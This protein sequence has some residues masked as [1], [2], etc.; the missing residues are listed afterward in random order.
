MEDKHKARLHSWTTWSDPKRRSQRI[1]SRADRTQAVELPTQQFSANACKVSPCITKPPNDD[2]PYSV[3]GMQTLIRTLSQKPLE[4][5]YL[6]WRARI[7]SALTLPEQRNAE[8]RSRH[9]IFCLGHVLST[10]KRSAPFAKPRE[11][12][13]RRQAPSSG[14]TPSRRGRPPT[15]LW[16]P[17]LTTES[18]PKWQ[19]STQGK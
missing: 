13:T 19:W 3:L 15:G 17:N 12:T 2:N 9:V 14:H 4:K 10:P 11:L 7:T 6:Y 1:L 16:K 5:L 8:R 18:Q